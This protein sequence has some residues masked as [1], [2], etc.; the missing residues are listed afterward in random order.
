LKKYF[1]GLFRVFETQED[2]ESAIRV[3]ETNGER[4][5]F[6]IKGDVSSNFWKKLKAGIL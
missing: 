3:T 1:F 4:F 6:Y 2:A 5:L